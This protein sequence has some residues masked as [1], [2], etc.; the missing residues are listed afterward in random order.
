MGIVGTRDS[1]YILDK[2]NYQETVKE[3]SWLQIDNEEYSSIK[4][5]L[6]SS[7]SINWPF[8]AFQGLNNYLVVINALQKDFLNR[9]QISQ[10]NDEPILE[11]YIT[12]QNDLF[13]FT[14]SKDDYYKL[15]KMDLSRTMHFNKDKQNKFTLD[16][17]ILMF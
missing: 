5:K 1:D 15:Y 13:V 2:V 14:S 12:S 9:I 7:F 4:G 6:I 3:N 8:V 10:D 11:T 16:K 17:P